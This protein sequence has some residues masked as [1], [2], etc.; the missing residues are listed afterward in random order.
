MVR[1]FV[2]FLLL[3]ITLI[4]IYNCFDPENLSLDDI[5][6]M[7]NKGKRHEIPTFVYFHFKKDR[8]IDMEYYK[9]IIYQFMS[10]VQLYPSFVDVNQHQL[11]AQ[12]PKG[13]KIDKDAIEETFSDVMEKVE[14]LETI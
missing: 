14:V 11:M 2:I 8:E 9:R 5:K 7:N 6:K 3:T 4:S 12:F 13:S 1:R 10:T